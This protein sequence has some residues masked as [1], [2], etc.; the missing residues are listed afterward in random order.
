MKTETDEWKH[1]EADSTMEVGMGS[2]A[3]DG[4]EAF[5]RK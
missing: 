5:A 1:S 3:C 4:T 2:H